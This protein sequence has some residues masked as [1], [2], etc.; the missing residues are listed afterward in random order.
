M[1]AVLGMLLL[2]FK[3]IMLAV[4]PRNFYYIFIL[5][6]VIDDNLGI[7]EQC[8]SRFGRVDP[9]QQLAHENLVTG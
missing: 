5:R 1:R 2:N 3:T 7:L 9:Y 6:C 8:L 4:V